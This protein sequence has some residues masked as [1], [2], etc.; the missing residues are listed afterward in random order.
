MNSVET[1]NC[2]DTDFTFFFIVHASDLISYNT[3][4][5]M[6]YYMIILGLYMLTASEW[7]NTN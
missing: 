5:H 2:K 7:I 4:Y 3:S 1:F 6:I